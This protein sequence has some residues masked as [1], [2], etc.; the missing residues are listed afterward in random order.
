M[1]ALKEDSIERAAAK[2]PN[3]QGVKFSYGTAGFRMLFVSCSLFIEHLQTH[4]SSLCRA[5]QLDGVVFRVALVAALRSASMNGQTIGLM[6]TA[7][8]NPEQV[9]ARTYL[10]HC[11]LSTRN[12]RTMASR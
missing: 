4:S 8:H 9:R 12:E 6:I 1:R 3:P 7:S 2:H 5:T 10:T 11:K